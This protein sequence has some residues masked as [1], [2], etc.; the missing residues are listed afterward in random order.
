MYNLS[1]ERAD[2]FIRYALDC[3]AI[4]AVTD[5]RGTI[6]FVNE[7]FCEISGYSRNELIGANHRILR[8]GVHDAEFFRSMYHQIANGR[9]WHGEICNKKK[10]GEI[11]WVDTTIVPHVA[12]SGKV[13][14]YTA[15][16]FDITERKCV[17]AQLRESRKQLEIVANLDVLTDLP[18]RRYFQSYL[19]KIIAKR[20]ETGRVIPP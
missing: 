10:N 14:S 12:A 1:S 15:I 5:V 3:S 13:D 9:N 16:R 18:N 20:A 19:E 7:K 6:T 4:V 8:S 2:K 11:Y 17:E